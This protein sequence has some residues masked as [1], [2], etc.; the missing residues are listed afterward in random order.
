[1]AV[2]VV[3]FSTSPV[4]VRWSA[5]LSG[6]EIAWARLVVAAAVVWIL[7]V[8]RG[9]R[10]RLAWGD[11]PR[12]ALFGLITALHFWFYVASLS[13]TTVAHSLTLVYTAP[14][15]VVLFSALFLKEPLARRKYLGVLVTV[16]GAAVLAG[17]EPRFT[18][19]MALGDLLALGSAVYF[20]FYS[21]AGRSQRDRYPLLTYAFAVYGMAALWLTPA[22]L[23]SHTPGWGMQQV[24]SVVALGVFPL[25]LGHTLYN[26]AL[27]R[28][29]AAYVNLIATQEVTGGIVLG[30]LFL[31]E[32]PGPSTLLGV[33]T[34]LAG[35]VLVLL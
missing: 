10:P 20:G 22:A 16:V 19:Q 8:I 5:P 11:A 23:L 24:L 21:V 18:S 3:F 26:A 9:E 15:F 33:A 2:A 35:I 1:V 30:A 13:H 14:I 12:F 27:R 29:H 31:G 6:W 28:T 34:A 4:L 32:V 25:A 17:F 7:A